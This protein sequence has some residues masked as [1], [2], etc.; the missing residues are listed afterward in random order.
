MEG[1]QEFELVEPFDAP[2]GSMKKIT[3]EHAFAMGVERQIFRQR[4]P[5]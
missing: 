1:K 2:K 3:P 5:P 4:L